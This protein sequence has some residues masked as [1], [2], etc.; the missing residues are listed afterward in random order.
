MKF[1]TTVPIVICSVLLAGIFM[2]FLVPATGSEMDGPIVGDRVEIDLGRVDIDINDEWIDGRLWSTVDLENALD[3]PTN[4]EPSVPAISHPL[5]VPYEILDIELL[6]SDPISFKLPFKLPPSPT[7]LPLTEENMQETSPLEPDWERYHSG[8]TFPANPLLWKRMGWSWNNGQRF[9]HY[10]VSASPIDYDP[11]EDELTFYTSVKLVLTV[12]GPEPSLSLDTEPTRSEARAP[13][14]PPLVHSGTELLVI[15]HDSYLD[16][17]SPYIEW[18]REKGV[19]VSAVTI[20]QVDQQYPSD[21]RTTSIWKYVHDTFFGDSQNL[22]FLLLVG[23]H[24]QVASRTVKDLDPYAPAGEPSTLHTDTYFGCLD[25]GYGN[26]NSDGDQDWGELNDI[27]DY[28]PEVYVSRIPVNSESEAKGWANKVVAYERDVPVGDWGGTAALLG[29]YTHEFDDGPEHCEYLWSSYLSSVYSTPDKYY[30]NGDVRAST[31]AKLLT[32][33][34]LQT[35]ISSGLSIIVYMGHG[36]WAIWTEGPQDASSYL[37]DSSPASQLQQSPKLPFISAMSCET[38]WFDSSHESISEA[39]TENGKGGAIAYGGATRTTEGAIGHGYLIGAPGIQEDTLRML[40][41]GYRAPAE[42]FQRAK[43]YYAEQWGAYFASYQFGYNAWM[44]HQILGAPNVLLWTSTPKT[45]GVQYD[46]DEDHYTNFTVTV[47]DGQNN[48]VKDARVSIYSATLGERSFVDTDTMGRAT[49]P[50]IISETAYG[51]ITVTKQNFKP[52][53]KEIVLR[54]LTEPETTPACANQNPDGANGWYVSDPLLS[55]IC[56]EPADIFFKWNGGFVESYKG[57]ILQVPKGPNVLEYWAEDGSGNEEDR[58]YHSINYDPE[59]PVASVSLEPE[60]PDGEG[61]WY[62]TPPV[63]SV[64]LQQS[65]GSPQRVDYWWGRDPRQVSNGTLIAPE[66][67]NELHIQAVDEAGNR[68]EEYQF[69]LKVDSVGPMTTLGTGGVDPNE[70]G[71]YVSPMTVTLTSDDRRSYIYYRWGPEEEFSRYSTAITPPP[72]NN[73]LQYYSKDEHGNIEPL[74]SVQVPYDIMPPDLEVTVTPRSPDGNSRWYVTKPRLALD[75]SFEDNDYRI[76]YYFDGDDPVEYISPIDIQ[77]G[78]W[79]LHSFAE[80]EAGNRGM[81][82]THDFKVDTRS[83]PTQEYIDLSPNE[84]GWYTDLPQIILSSS[85]MSQIF[86]SWDGLTGYE[87]YSGGLYPPGEEGI[88]NLIYYS[89]DQAGNRESD[90]YLTLPLDGKA[91]VVSMEAPGSVLPGEEVVFDLSG[92]TDGVEVN[93]YRIDFGDGTD[94]GWVVT[95]RI[96]HRY[97]G[98]GSYRVTVK[99]RDGVGHE[100]EENTWNIEVKNELNIVLVLVVG[101]S[102][103]VLILILALVAAVL[104]NR[105]RHHHFAHHPVTHPLPPQLPRHPAAAQQPLPGIRQAPGKQPLPPVRPNTPEAQQRPA[106]MTRT[107]VDMPKPPAPPSIPE[108][109]RPPIYI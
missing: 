89:I 30:S 108:P 101:V 64:I 58:K 93:A 55:F 26:Y 99:A 77:D 7:V 33:S 54:D 35:G 29:S 94:S 107:S 38:N 61:G 104:V 75:V 106:P 36:H 44:E 72:G 87:K 34:N 70:K 73:T 14:P 24:D 17:L 76:Y 98:S 68:D 57:G 52:F 11:G 65:M 82:Q 25:G 13:D 6:R 92:T 32:Y 48:P 80:D 50:Y 41:Q 66:G 40:K 10:S 37:Y 60:E 1:R 96:T 49:I 19:C 4:G 8:E 12:G 28:I 3:P 23:E 42:V 81:L 79:T 69:F 56:T 109:P 27:L 90:R 2:M 22:K 84:E 100:S 95:P 39:F 43:A 62:T 74:R 85:G 88:F 31:G 78:E 16:E 86:Y 5:E 63:I 15:S 105:R 46:F 20:S 47:K 71:W 59:T 67:D 83:D 97:S 51:K 91:P 103:V 45:F 18:N 102:V 21:D 53:Q 9:G